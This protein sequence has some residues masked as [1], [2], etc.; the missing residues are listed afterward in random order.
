MNGFRMVV[1]GALFSLGC[2]GAVGTGNDPNGDPNG[3][4]NNN[5][6][7]MSC[8]VAPTPSTGET[9][10]VEA[11]GTV[12][13]KP[14]AIGTTV[15]F[16]MPIRESADTDE[17]IIGGHSTNGAFKVLTPYPIYVPRGETVQVEVSFTPSEN[18]TVSS[19]LGLDTAK[20]GT[21]HVALKGTG[22]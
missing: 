9:A 10:T 15:R 12:V 17:T 13:F 3:N 14:I 22:L 2:S 19:D 18:G 7:N 4:N 1:L 5:P 21:S 20:M 11:D 6:P 16:S 8:G